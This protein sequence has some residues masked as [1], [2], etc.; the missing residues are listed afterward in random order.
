MAR[1]DWYP[2]SAKITEHFK[3]NVFV[4]TQGP[5]F[6]EWIEA[7]TGGKLIQE[8]ND[9]NVWVNSFLVFDDDKDLT[10]FLLKWTN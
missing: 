6:F 8:F 1:T 3:Y 5:D 10:V 7:E 2:V 9:L 4:P